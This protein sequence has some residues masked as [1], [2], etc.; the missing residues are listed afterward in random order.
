MSNENLD[1]KNKLL[2]AAIDIFGL[3]G[4]VTTREITEKAGVNV[5]AINYYFGNKNNLLKEVE[6]Y[7]ANLLYS[8][9]HEIL[10]N[11][12]LNPT[13]KLMKWAYNLTAFMFQFPAIIELIANLAALDKSY[14]PTLIERVYLD[15]EVQDMIED[16]IRK[17]TGCSD[18]ET[19]KHKYLQIFS[20][21][22]GLVVHHIIAKTYFSEKSIVGID[23]NN[24]LEEYIER[25]VNNILSK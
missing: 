16:G 15:K 14:N 11:I 20:G 25:V 6:G 4:E 17:G 8:M 2:Q 10:N 19:I 24:E 18:S 1:T 9:Q 22:I 12:S 13:E 3:K 23:S 7:Y 5:A 21:I